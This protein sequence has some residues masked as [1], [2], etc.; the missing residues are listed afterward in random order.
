MRLLLYCENKVTWD[1][2][3]NLLGFAFKYNLI[4][5]LHSLFNLHI[6]SLDI[7]DNLAALA[8]RA[9]CGS[10]LPSPSTSVAS[11][12]HLHLHSETNLNLLH[13]D[14]LPL[15]LR[16]LLC[17]SV[18]CSSSAT[19]RAVYVPSN[20]HVSCSSQ[21]E[22]FECDPYICAC[23]W[24]LLP[25][26]ASPLKPLESLVALLIIYLSLVL[27]A[28]HLICPVDLFECACG[29][30]IARVLVRVVLQA[31]LAESALDVALGGFTRDL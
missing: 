28:E 7:I 3:W 13:D 30:L 21:I 18:F 29:L 8:M 20:R 9:V 15:T 26:V 4:A 14:A 17:L 22:F 11:C 6:Q 31:E 5:I 16:A 23:L 19:L 25:L 2:V 24:P 12:L 27:V 10:D 1:H